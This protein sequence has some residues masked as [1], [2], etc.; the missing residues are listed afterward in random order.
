LIAHPSSSFKRSGN[1]DEHPEGTGLKNGTSWVNA[2]DGNSPSGNGYTKLADS[3]RLAMSGKQ[4]WI[5][6]GTYK[7]T[8]RPRLSAAVTW[9]NTSVCNWW[10]LRFVRANFLFFHRLILSFP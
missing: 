8:P 2:L 10:E 3:I 5:A 9:M 6:E 7:P 1:E 4:F